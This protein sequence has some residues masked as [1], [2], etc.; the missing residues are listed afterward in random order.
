MIILIMN[1]YI[2]R[3]R[4]PEFV[5]SWDSQRES[6]WYLEKKGKWLIPLSIIRKANV[7][8]IQR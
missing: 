1:T 4:T 5:Y 3:M 6:D 7:S 8:G 2:L